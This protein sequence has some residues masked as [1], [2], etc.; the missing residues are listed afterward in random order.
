MTGGGP[1]PSLSNERAINM[2][3]AEARNPTTAEM[4]QVIRETPKVDP[5]TKAVVGS[6]EGVKASAAEFLQ[7]AI[8]KAMHLAADPNADPE[9]RSKAASLLGVLAKKEG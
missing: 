6:S 1:G 4:S 5:V 8:K 2:T 3:R 7:V 9:E